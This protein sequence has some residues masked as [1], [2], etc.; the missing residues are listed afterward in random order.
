MYIHIDSAELVS[1]L[2]SFSISSRTLSSF[3][4][5]HYEIS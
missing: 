1:F 3:L 2:L 5:R 4:L